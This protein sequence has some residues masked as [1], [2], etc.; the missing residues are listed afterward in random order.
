MADELAAANAKTLMLSL[1]GILRYLPFAVL[2]DGKEFLIERYA[3]NMQT[4]AVRYDLKDQPK[5]KWQVAGFGVSQA[6][7][8][9]DPVTTKPIR[10]DPL[11][12]VT[13]E[14]KALIRQN[15]E[16]EGL[17]PGEIYLDDA[18][19]KQKLTKVL[20]REQSSP[21]IH[22][23]SHFELRP[24]D[25]SRSF[26]LLGNNTILTMAEVYD[27][28][29]DFAGIDLVTLSACDTAM[30]ENNVLSN[31][32]EIEN[33]GA[34]VQRQGAKSVMATLWPVIDES[35]SLFMKRFYQLREQNKLTKAEALR[36]AQL[37]MITSG[38]KFAHPYYW[39][40]FVL[41]GNWL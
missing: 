34:L 28:N 17:L 13:T 37:S 10:F 7:D 8:V 21:V 29:M 11:P 20:S 24:G 5:E 39:A 4:L 38:D 12:F 6:A 25:N 35:T 18:F 2:H 41:M 32:A 27:E 22:I 14:L 31:G 36:Q 15:D 3:I 16:D 9:V 26:L 1:D 19:S 40:P 33:F 23:G 30:G